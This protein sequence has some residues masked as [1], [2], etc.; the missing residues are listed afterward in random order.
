MTK[1]QSAYKLQ[2]PARWKEKI[3]MRVHPV[4]KR[5][6]LIPPALARSNFHRIRV[7]G[8]VTMHDYETFGSDEQGDFPFL[9]ET[10]LATEGPSMTLLRWRQGFGGEERVEMDMVGSLNSTSH[11]CLVQIAI[12]FYEGAT[13]GTTE[14]EDSRVFESIVPPNATSNFD[15]HLANNE[16]DWAR[17][18]GS[19]AN[20]NA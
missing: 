2:I 10:I 3:A 13:E 7:S 6:V 15:V 17:V 20:T 11:T 5:N 1:T 8:T 14:L 16:D 9:R 12:R 18:V 4:F 19:I